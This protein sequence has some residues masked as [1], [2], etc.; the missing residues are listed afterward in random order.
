MDTP[1]AELMAEAAWESGWVDASG[2]P[3]AEVIAA[4]RP[5]RTGTLRLSR[6]AGGLPVSGHFP[7]DDT[8][9]ALATLEDMMPISV[10]RF[11]PWFVSI[12]VAA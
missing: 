1:R 7:L 3:L 2:R 5:Y 10:R 9:A 8:N 12:N 11:T 6:A 4:L